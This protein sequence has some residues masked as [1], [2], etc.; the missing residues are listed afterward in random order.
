[1]AAQKE[2]L[3]EVARS[4]SFKLSQGVPQYES[5]DFFCSRKEE[6]KPEDADRVSVALHVWCKQQVLL[7]VKEY[8]TR[9]AQP[10]PAKALSPARQR[11]AETQDE[12]PF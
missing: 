11:G 8:K 3:V 6:C 7:A 12:L 5:R 2:K 9:R 4:F 1:M 10:K